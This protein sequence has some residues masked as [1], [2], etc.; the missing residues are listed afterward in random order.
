MFLSPPLIGVLTSAAL[1]SQLNSALTKLLY[2]IYR[3]RIGGT[4]HELRLFSPF[5]FFRRVLVIYL[6][7]CKALLNKL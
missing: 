3:I 5:F 7:K 2:I 1:V 4:G 6:I